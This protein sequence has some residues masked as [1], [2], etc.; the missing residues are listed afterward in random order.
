MSIKP[1]SLKKSS[2]MRAPSRSSEE[3]GVRSLKTYTKAALQ[4]PL[5]FGDT[6]LLQTPS[7]LGMSRPS[8]GK[9]L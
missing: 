1:A 4:N 3:A 6:G 7:L 2:G 8:K 5:S 9:K